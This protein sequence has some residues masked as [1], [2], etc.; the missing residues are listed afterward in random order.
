MSH[1]LGRVHYPDGVILD[2]RRTERN[3]RSF[4]QTEVFLSESP[5]VSP[6]TAALYRSE[7]FDLRLLACFE[8]SAWMYF[9]VLFYAPPM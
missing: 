2:S 6:I 4:G 3:C 1:G 8:A 5:M 9:L 7:P